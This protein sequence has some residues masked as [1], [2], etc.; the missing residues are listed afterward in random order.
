MPGDVILEINRKQVKNIADFNKL[1]KDA[2]KK[3][4]MLLLIHRGKSTIY[5]TI[6]IG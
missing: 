6:D 5:I 2:L 3:N 1:S 4:P